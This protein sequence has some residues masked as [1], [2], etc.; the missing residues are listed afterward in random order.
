MLQAIRRRTRSRVVHLEDV[1]KAL[2]RGL[3]LFVILISGRLQAAELFEYQRPIT[4]MGMGGVHLPF[5]RDTDAVMW[6]PARLGEID[7]ISWEIF[8]INAGLNGL[9]LMNS[10]GSSDCTGSGCYSEYYGKPIW[11]GYYG[12][13]SFTAPRMGVTGF[14]SG[15][16][17]GTLHNPAFPE[18]N[19]TFIND[20]GVAFGFGVPIGQSLTAGITL[21]RI[22]RWGGTQLIS[23]SSLSGGG[24]SGLQN[25]M[26]EFQNKGTGYGVDLAT[27]WRLPTPGF[28]T[29]MAVHWQ[30]VGYTSFVKT[31]GLQAPPT[32][33]DNLSF[34][35]GTGMDLPGLDWA[36]GLEY[37]HIGLQ[38]E[39]LGK[40]LHF[41]AELSLP[42]ID[43]R[44]GLH[45]G[46]PTL[47][48]SVDLFFLRLDAASYTE[49]VGVYP[50]QTPSNRLRVGLS[51]EFAIDANFSFT[52]KDGSRRK[53]KQRR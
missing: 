28:N 33:R 7:E 8:D 35:L 15:Y 42:L 25:L 30:D 23:L 52:S 51:M 3:L 24:E 39:Q 19:L 37:R 6:N 38:G 1:L 41:G 43:L 10:I 4:A 31:D 40:K 47:G 16:L 13:T 22:A 5:V 17:E 46:Y 29:V 27:Q 32:I 49:E 12:Q 34:G 2:I 36:V 21:K 45:Q 18:F 20:Y 26:D 11:V 53:L 9:D 44:A 50:G 14:N 48:A